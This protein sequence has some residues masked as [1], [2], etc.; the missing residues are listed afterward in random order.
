MSIYSHV[1]ALRQLF[2]G[3]LCTTVLSSSLAVGWVWAWLENSHGI[4]SN[5]GLADGL[6]YKNAGAAE[7]WVPVAFL[8]AERPLWPSH[9]EHSLRAF[10][11][12]LKT[13]LECLITVD[14]H[15]RSTLWLFFSQALVILWFS[16][17][18]TYKLHINLHFLFQTKRSGLFVYQKWNLQRFWWWFFLPRAE[19]R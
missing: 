2:Y 15:T 12:P 16:S 3:R 1:C 7:L 17:S 19:L 5:A 18:H 6:W 9:G 10:K 11:Q 13:T 14:S 4:W 8:T